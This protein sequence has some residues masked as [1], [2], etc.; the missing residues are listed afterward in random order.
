MNKIYERRWLRFAKVGKMKYIGH[1]DL[2]TIFHGAI[3]RAKLPIAYSQGFNPHQR[4]SFALPLP[5]GMESLCEYVELILEEPADIALDEY[6]PDGLRVLEVYS[7]PE[8]APR[9]AAEVTA[10][11]YRITTSLAKQAYDKITSRAEIVVLKKTKSG[12]KEVDIKPDILDISYEHGD[13]LKLRLS[14]GSSKNLSPQIIINEFLPQEMPS[15][16]RTEMYA[17]NGKALH[18]IL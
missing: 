9:P 14:A 7:V 3:R 15:I 6:L 12:E 1:L 11:D 5:V 17:S 8:K 2:Q 18:E 4:I 10:V 13:V 16:V